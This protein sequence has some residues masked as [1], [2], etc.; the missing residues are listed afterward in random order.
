MNRVCFILLHH[1]LIKEWILT[2]FGFFAAGRKHL[3]GSGK[4]EGFD[5]GEWSNHR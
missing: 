1:I 2:V 4:A 3:G 5:D